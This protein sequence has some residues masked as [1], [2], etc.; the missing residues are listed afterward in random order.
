MLISR[1]VIDI[2]SDENPIKNRDYLEWVSL[3]RKSSPNRI[4][5]GW[6]GTTPMSIGLLVKNNRDTS[7]HSISFK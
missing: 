6:Q 3:G 7:W 5:I 2:Q 1:G 4:Y